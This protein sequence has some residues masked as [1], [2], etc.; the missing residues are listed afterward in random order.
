MQSLEAWLAERGPQVAAALEQ[1]RESICEIV[2]A[3]L[4]TTY[5]RLCYDPG[6]S[7]ALAFQQQTFRE[8][9][10]RFHRLMQVLLQFH[11]PEVIERGYRWGW[12]LL[13]RYGVER[14]HLLTQ[15]RS[16]FEAAHANAALDAI[17]R[18]YLRDLEVTVLHIIGEITTRHNQCR[19]IGA[20]MGRLPPARLSHRMLNAS[21]FHFAAAA[22]PQNENISDDPYLALHKLDPHLVLPVDLGESGQVIGRGERPIGWIVDANQPGVARLKRDQQS[23]G[24]LDAL[25]AK[26]LDPR[27]A[28]G[29]RRDQ[30]IGRMLICQRP[31]YELIAHE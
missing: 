18:A 20:S 26:I 6:R 23:G 19:A 8:T 15:V 1:K 2:A 11:A 17:D 30:R 13:Q 3:R 22:P 9:P 25:R 27:T 31:P 29:A 5:P 28:V 7:D 4:E 21:C 10:R 24:V 14:S 12:A 16:Y